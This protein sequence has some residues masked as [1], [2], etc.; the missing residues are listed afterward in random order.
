MDPLWPP[1]TRIVSH[2]RSVLQSVP[3]IRSHGR[4]D[5]GSRAQGKEEEEEEEDGG[6]RRRRPFSEVDDNEAA[7][8][9]KSEKF[10]RLSRRTSSIASVA[11]S[12][13]T[14]PGNLP[15]VPESSTTLPRGQEPHHREGA[16]LVLSPADR[17]G[18]GER[19]V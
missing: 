16:L 12:R 10:E 14:A 18:G 5:D 7:A 9:E 17:A 4:E 8:E 13:G 15:A 6:A 19:A 3:S 1:P 2:N 11:S